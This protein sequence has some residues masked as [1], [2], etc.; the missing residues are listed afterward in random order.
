MNMRGYFFECHIDY[1]IDYF[2]NSYS[3]CFGYLLQK[4][5]P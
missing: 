3:V 2:V 4:F 5:R 1:F